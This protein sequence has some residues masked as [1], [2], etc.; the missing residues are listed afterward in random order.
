[1]QDFKL[2]ERMVSILNKNLFICFLLCLSSIFEL[3]S[4]ERK[5]FKSKC[6]LCDSGA[7]LHE[8]HVSL[9]GNFIKDSNILMKTDNFYI[10]LD[11]YP[12][13][14]DHILIIPK[15]HDV[16]YSTLNNSLALELDAIIHTLSDIV[17][18]EKFGLFEHGSNMIN[19]KQVLCGNSVYH[20]HLHFIPNLSL[21]KNELRN[22]FG[23]NGN[24]P[25]LISFVNNIQLE[26]FIT[27]KTNNLTFLNYLK[28]LPT[29]EPY[30]FC[31]YSSISNESLCIPDNFILVDILQRLKNV[32]FWLQTIFA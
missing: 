7:H 19:G 11:N 22:L 18:T 32:G 16:S 6:V 29:K 25:P 26:A 31:Y 1:M 28:K 8:K 27:K 3:F 15:K 14:E 2:G 23:L 9:Y 12:V 13:C 21:E 10:A 20:A 5:S 24:K 17:G 4:L 30:L